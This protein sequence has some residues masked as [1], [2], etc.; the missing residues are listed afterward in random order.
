MRR[1]SILSECRRRGVEVLPPY[2]DEAEADFTVK[3]GKIMIGLSGVKQCGESAIR[4]ILLR[5]DP[6]LPDWLDRCEKRKVTART[7]DFLKKAGA[8]R[9]YKPTREEEIEALGYSISGRGI[10][11]FPY[12]IVDGAGEIIDFRPIVTKTGKP[13][14]FVEVE[15]RSETK[16]LTIFP[17]L[18]SQIKDKILVGK[19][20][21]W[22]IKRDIVENIKDCERAFFD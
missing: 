10:D 5:R 11:C 20:W 14:C 4:E 19:I 15:F 9:D 1:R 16:R 8:F 3:N 17:E 6:L 12:D 22:E 18:W 13:M 2:I 7:V 21:Q